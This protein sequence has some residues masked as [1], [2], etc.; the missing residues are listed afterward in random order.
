MLSR[1]TTLLVTISNKVV[2]FETLNDF[3][4]TDDN[5]KAIWEEI[6][7][8]QHRGDLL[9][10]EGYIYSNGIICLFLELPLETK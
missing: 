7:T 4:E 10:L 2:R 3:Y 6:D 8:K 1:R 5:F 9:I